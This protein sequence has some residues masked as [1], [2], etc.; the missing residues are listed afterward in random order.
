MVTMILC[1]STSIQYSDE[2]KH[3]GTRMMLV[4]NVALGKCKDYTEHHKD[5]QGPPEGFNS[6]H[7]VASIKTEP[8]QF[9]V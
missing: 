8:S 5:L 6:C 4:S 9:K 7:G 3:K 1:F 2:S